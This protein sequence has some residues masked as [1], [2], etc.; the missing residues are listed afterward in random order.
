MSVYDSFFENTA[1][2]AKS[3]GIQ[4]FRLLALLVSVIFA[5]C[6]MAATEGMTDQR[7]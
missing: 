6:I 3:Y 1:N 4:L 2:N 7:N 5:N